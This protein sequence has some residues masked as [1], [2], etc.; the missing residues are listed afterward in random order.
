MMTS[1][2]WQKIFLKY[3]HC[4]CKHN[5]VAHFNRLLTI[6]VYLDMQGEIKYNDSLLQYVPYWGHLEWNT[7][8]IWGMSI[9]KILR[10][11]E[12]VTQ[13]EAMFICVMWENTCGVLPFLKF[14]IVLNFSF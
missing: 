2:F 6:S 11:L 9:W 8:Y 10:N 12:D 5:A 13:K 14:I 1:T 7:Q 3:S 4:F